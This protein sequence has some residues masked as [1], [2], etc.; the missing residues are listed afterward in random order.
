MGMDVCI[1]L[2]VCLGSAQG[3][4]APLTSNKPD[5]MHLPL[6]VFQIIITSLMMLTR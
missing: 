4:G 5:F 3:T 6:K 1:Y 2:W